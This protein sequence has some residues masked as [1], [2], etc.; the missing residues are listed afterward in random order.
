[1]FMPGEIMLM[2]LGVEDVFLITGV[3]ALGVTDLFA[4]GITIV[5]DFGFPVIVT[6]GFISK[7]SIPGEVFF[8]I[9]V[10]PCSL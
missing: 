3:V 2:Y 1:M 10:D 5:V 7:V 9:L 6:I 8:G 4:L